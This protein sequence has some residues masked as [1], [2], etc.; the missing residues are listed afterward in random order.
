MERARRSP[1]SRLSLG[2]R[3][4]RIPPRN[5]QITS[6]KVSTPLYLSCFPLEPP[7]FPSP[8]DTGSPPLTRR[9][10]IPKCFLKA[11]LSLQGYAS[12]FTQ[13][14]GQLENSRRGA[15][16]RAR[17]T[18]ES[19]AS[20]RLGEG[21]TSRNLIL[22]SEHGPPES[23]SR[24]HLKPLHPSPAAPLGAAEPALQPAQS[25]ILCGS[26][27]RLSSGRRRGKRQNGGRGIG[28]ED[29]GLMSVGERER[30]RRR[31]GVGRVEIG[32]AGL[33]T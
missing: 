12:P 24:T 25:R 16:A 17:V 21:D 2:A 30:G 7:M 29:E 20:A 28:I 15:E 32:A 33:V 19:A 6:P 13:C 9:V 11:L 26:R 8:P 27:K 18:L 23:Q 4:R 10:T 5:S 22:A 1:V 14:V 3:K 31:F